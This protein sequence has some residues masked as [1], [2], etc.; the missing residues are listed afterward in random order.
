LPSKPNTPDVFWLTIGELHAKLV[1]KEF[2]CEEL[3]KA[4]IER[5]EKVGPRYNALALSL[6]KPALSR[7]KEI[8]KELKRERTRGPLQGVPYG[9]KDLF[10][11]AKFPTAWGAKPYAGQVFEE[12]ATVVKKL[13]NAGAICLGKLGMVE[14]AGGGGYRYAA[15]SVTGPGL[16]PWDTGRWSGGS[17]SGSGAA[18]AAGLVGYALGSETWGSIVTPAAYCGVTGLRPTYGLVSR[19]GAMALSWTLDK[20]GPICRSAVDCGLVLNGIAGGDANDPGSAG[21]GFYYAPEYVRANKDLTIGYAPRDLEVIADPAVAKVFADTY[22]VFREMGF[23]M[24]EV[25]LPEMPYSAAASTI[26]GCEASSIF[27]ELISSGKVDQLADQNQIQGLKASFDYTARDY[28]KAMR[29]RSLVQSAFRK[30]FDDVDVLLAPSRI[31]IASPIGEDLE[32]PS[33]NTKEGVTLPTRGLRDLGAAGNLAGLPLLSMP[34]GFAN[35][36]PLGI[37]LVTRPFTE[38]TILGMGQRYQDRTDWHKRR[39]KVD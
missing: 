3:T 27:E 31:N 15:A 10:S 35:G 22:A 34:C 38:N 25:S 28:L 12:H 16:N 17:S 14:L 21:K 29:I 13:D 9:A 5:L 37:S 19:A 8:D 1:A 4:W 33:G 2:S 26:I 11:F 36:M 23:V 18:V 7:A 20:V 6:R 32:K 30:V 39:P 24:K